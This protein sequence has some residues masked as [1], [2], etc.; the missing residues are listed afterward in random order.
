[1]AVHTCSTVSTHTHM[2]RNAY[3]VCMLL[4]D[5]ES[6]LRIPT[7]FVELDY[8]LCYCISL[9][10]GAIAERQTPL[11]NCQL[12]GPGIK[13]QLCMSNFRIVEGNWGG[14]CPLSPQ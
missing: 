1:M 13:I 3:T 2:H 12:E 10:R 9:S 5:Q 6:Y 14:F 7:A 11:S 4:K 8:G